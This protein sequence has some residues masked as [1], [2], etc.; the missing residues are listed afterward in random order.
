MRMVNWMRVRLASAPA[1]DLKF[2]FFL[3]YMFMAARKEPLYSS[4]S[5]VKIPSVEHFVSCHPDSVLQ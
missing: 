1:G 4:T 5:S 3:H 2:P